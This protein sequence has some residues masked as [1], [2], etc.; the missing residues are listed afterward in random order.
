MQNSFNSTP[1]VK[2]YDARNQFYSYT[3]RYDRKNSILLQLILTQAQ[4]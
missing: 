4:E 2:T 1:L 3:H